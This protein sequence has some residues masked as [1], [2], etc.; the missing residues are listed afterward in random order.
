M[1]AFGRWEFT[2]D[3][4][5]TIA[6]YERAERGGSDECKCDGCRNFAATR[7]VVYP[8]AFLSF[9]HSLG[10]DFHKDGEVYH[11]ARIGPGRHDYDGW[12]HF[13]GTLEKTGDFSV[14]PM[15]DSFEAWLLR[16]SA[17]AI[18]S[19][20]GLPLVEVAFHATAVPWLLNETEPT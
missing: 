18:P 15:S 12:F 5:A 16:K 3:R 8:P 20:R 19:L 4:D 14:V 6:A 11:N 2:I 1:S 7:D 9:L 10:I 17:P 13:V